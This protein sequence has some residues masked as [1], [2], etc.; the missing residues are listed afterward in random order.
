MNPQHYGTSGVT[1]VPKSA[2]LGSMGQLDPT[3]FHSYFNDFDHFAA[4]D[5]TITRVGTTPTEAL[6]D[7]DGGRLLLTTTAGASDSTFLNKVG[8]SFALVSGKEAW[9]KA[10]MKVSDATTSHFV[11]GLQVTD[12]TPLAVADGVWFQKD[13]GDALLDFHVAN[14]SVQTDQLGVATLVN[15]TDVEFTWHYDGKDS[16]E[17]FVNEVKVAT[18]VATN[19]PATELTVS[20]GIQNGAAAVK[21]ASLDYVLAAKE[22]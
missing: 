21:T 10:K 9:F 19:L 15:D 16:I 22:R 1:N 2:S 11:M 4:A 6:T 12:T 5:W 17:V 14:T 13:S 3:R 18:V 8:E 20:F 7:A